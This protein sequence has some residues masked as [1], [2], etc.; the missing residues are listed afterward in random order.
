MSKHTVSTKNSNCPPRVP[1]IY[2]T[3]LISH[4]IAT[5]PSRT[6]MNDVPAGFSTKDVTT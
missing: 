1:Y 6:C 3:S 5:I 4:K 2:H